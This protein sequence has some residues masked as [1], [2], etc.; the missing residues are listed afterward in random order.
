MTTPRTTREN[1][2]CALINVIEN[3]PEKARIEL[4][5]A[6]KAYK[7]LRSASQWKRIVGT[8]VHEAIEDGL[9]DLFMDEEMTQ[10]ERADD[11]R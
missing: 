3:A 10:D 6:F 2:Q 1:F 11:R 9:S 8:T 7:E 4:F 5:E